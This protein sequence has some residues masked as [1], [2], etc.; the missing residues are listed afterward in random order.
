[1]LLLPTLVTLAPVI[2]GPVAVGWRR[3][4]S[5]LPAKEVFLQTPVIPAPAYLAL[6]VFP[7]GE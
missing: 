1:M 6:G 4:G 3:Q 2:P 7:G 5:R